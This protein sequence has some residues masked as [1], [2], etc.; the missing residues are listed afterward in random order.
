M[1]GPKPSQAAAPAVLTTTFAGV[2]GRPHLISQGCTC[3]P[4]PSR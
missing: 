2:C 4:R 3:A 1:N